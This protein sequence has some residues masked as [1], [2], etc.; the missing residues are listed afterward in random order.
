MLDMKT[1]E[2]GYLMGMFNLDYKVAL[3]QLIDGY[4]LQGMGEDGEYVTAQQ[5]APDMYVVNITTFS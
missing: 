3:F 4:I 5:V 1:D 2:N